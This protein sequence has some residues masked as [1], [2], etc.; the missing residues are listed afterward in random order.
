MD[1]RAVPA[2][3]EAPSDDIAAARS[4]RGLAVR[5]A[6]A[7]YHGAEPDAEITLAGQGTFYLFDHDTLGLDDDLHDVAF[8]FTLRNKAAVGVSGAYA[9]FRDGEG[10]PIT[11]LGRYRRG[12]ILYGLRQMSEDALQAFAGSVDFLRV[13]QHEL[14]HLR[15][16]ARTRWLTVRP[17]L[18]AT[19]RATYYNDPAEFN[20]YY[21]EVVANLTDMATARPDELADHAD[22]HGFTGDFKRDLVALLHGDRSTRAFLQWLTDDR[23]KALLRRVYKLHQH[24][25]ERMASPQ[26]ARVVEAKAVEPLLPATPENI[27]KAKAF[28]LKKWRERATER[29]LRAPTDLSSSCKFSSLFAQRVFG[30]KLRGN[31]DHQFVVLPDGKVLDLNL[32]AE[33]VRALDDPHR[34]DRSFWGN[35]EHRESMASCEPRVAAWVEEFRREMRLDESWSPTPEALLAAARGYEGIIHDLQGPPP[36]GRAADYDWRYEP[37][38]PLDRFREMTPERWRSYMRNEMQA[39][40]DEDWARDYEDIV[41]NDI[42]EPVIAVEIGGKAYLWDGFHRV[43]GSHLADRARIPAIIGTPKAL[44]EARRALR[45]GK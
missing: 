19:D 18:D 15:D 22:L 11:L 8:M 37:A 32:D 27:E 17:P 26:A 33:D 38:Y 42:R 7:L 28:V 34:H 6:A 31:W 5:I 43:G 1:Y 4:V 44:R 45:P 29:G 40:E 12:V 21:H 3:R 39:A 36:N 16:S 14:V 13:I 20:A 23:R 10:R 9:T 35:R 30:G 24:V 25:A 2:L 41:D